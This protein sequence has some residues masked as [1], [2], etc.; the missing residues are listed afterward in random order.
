MLLK[1]QRIFIRSSHTSISTKHIPHPMTGAGLPS[2]SIFGVMPRPGRVLAAIR[3][4]TRCGAPSAVLTVT[5]LLKSVITMFHNSPGRVY[6]LEELARRLG[7]TR[8]EGELKDLL[9]FG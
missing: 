6:S 7:R 1:M 2:T 3:P 8:N 5:K 9:D 4:L